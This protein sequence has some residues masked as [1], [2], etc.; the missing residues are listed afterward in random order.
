MALPATWHRFAALWPVGFLEIAWLGRV[1]R[2][3]ARSRRTRTLTCTEIESLQTSEAHFSSIMTLVNTH[4]E[5]NFTKNSMH[6]H[7]A[8]SSTTCKR[9]QQLNL[10]R[11]SQKTHKS[12]A[13]GIYYCAIASSRFRSRGLKFSRLHHLGDPASPSLRNCKPTF[14]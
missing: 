11:Q 2:C 14:P 13:V 9:L 5:A 12:N 1:K 3:S 6:L 7:T 8:N 10:S 4:A